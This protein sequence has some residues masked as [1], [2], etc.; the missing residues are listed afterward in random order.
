MVN[1]NHRR[2]HESIGNLTPA[3]VHFGR[4]LLQ[5]ED[6]VSKTLTT[7][8]T[9][10][11]HQDNGDDL[12]DV[13]AQFGLAFSHACNVE[14]ILANA[15]LA[16]DFVKKVVTERRKA[17]KPIYT[18]DDCAERFEDFLAKQHEQTMGDLVRGVIGLIE[19]DE[20]LEKPVED[21]RRRR[22]YL[23]HN[24]WRERGGEVISV[25]RRDIVD[26]I[27]DQEFFEQ[28]AKDL[29]DVA[30]AE[31]GKLGLDAEKLRT[32]VDERVR[33]LQRDLAK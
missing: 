31:I 18:N 27:A 28:L 13:Y 4:G 8:T 23:A 19:L 5:R 7:D 22:N 25:R 20:T 26:L 24:F 21:A 29:E 14:T 16:S 9:V 2:Y 17:G 15:I 30:T 1:Y 6:A 12:K 10:D 32:Q 33:K 11:N 3:D